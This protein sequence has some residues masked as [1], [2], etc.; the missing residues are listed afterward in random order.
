MKLENLDAASRAA[1]EYREAV[2]ALETAKEA[3]WVKVYL[4]TD[5]AVAGPSVGPCHA[6]QQSGASAGLAAVVHAAVVD[7]FKQHVEIAE[8]QLQKLGVEVSEH[9]D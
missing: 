1:R 8:E 4:G 9:R 2:I 5:R 3:G 6:T 7:Y